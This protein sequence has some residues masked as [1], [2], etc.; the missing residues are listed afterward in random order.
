MKKRSRW[1]PVGTVRPP[2]PLPAQPS[3]EVAEASRLLVQLDQ[4]L[5][6]LEKAVDQATRTLAETSQ[7]PSEDGPS[8]EGQEPRP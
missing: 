1:R 4:S 7:P 5:T 3:L 8:Q 6:Q 2:S